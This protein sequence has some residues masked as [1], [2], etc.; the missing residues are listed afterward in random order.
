MY[1]LTLHQ[2]K[3]SYAKCSC[4]ALEELQE[5]KAPELDHGDGVDQSRERQGGGGLRRG[6]R[7]K[8]RGKW[9][10]T[11]G[12]EGRSGGG[13][14]APQAVQGAALRKGLAP[15]LRMEGVAGGCG[16]WVLPFCPHTFILG[17]GSCGFVGFFACSH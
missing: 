8:E 6:K 11:C 7:K 2:H 16:H 5:Q 4:V 13:F 15:G 1:E 17:L 14:I 10:C 3:A 12:G 9:R